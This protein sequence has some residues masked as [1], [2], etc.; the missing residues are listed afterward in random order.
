MTAA[1]GHTASGSAGVYRCDLPEGHKGWH[2]Q[3]V[4]LRA[5]SPP[6]DR[7]MTER[8]NWGD[9]GLAVHASKDKRR[10]EESGR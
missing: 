9:D 8:T 5:T 7:T 1:C 6:F 3:S 4:K 2:E 10:R